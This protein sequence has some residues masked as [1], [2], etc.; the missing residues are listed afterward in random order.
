MS[1]I[2]HGT[3]TATVVATETVDSYTAQITITN[4]SQ[5]GEIYFTVDGSTPTVKGANSYPCLGSRAVA[6]VGYPA[7]STVK[8]ISATGPLEYSVVGEPS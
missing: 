2:A 4:R 8:L 6:T 7:V 3:L 5:T 1:R